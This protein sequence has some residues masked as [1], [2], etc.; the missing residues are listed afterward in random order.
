MCPRWIL[1]AFTPVLRAVRLLL[2]HSGRMLIPGMNGA[3]DNTDRLS[4]VI[5]LLFYPYSIKTY[6]AD[7]MTVTHPNFLSFISS[8]Y[9]YT[10]FLLLVS[11]LETNERRLYP[12]QFILWE[13]PGH[14]THSGKE[15]TS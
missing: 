4:S 1:G 13:E 11:H 3:Q 8:N 6:K 2:D 7:W 10:S 14:M 9:C 15:V 12:S 5:G